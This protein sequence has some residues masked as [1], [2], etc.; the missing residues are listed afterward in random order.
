MVMMNGL[1][2]D[3]APGNISGTSLIKKA[4]ILKMT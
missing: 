4:E 1:L 3:P 2:R